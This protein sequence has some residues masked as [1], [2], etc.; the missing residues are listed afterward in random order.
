MNADHEVR[1]CGKTVPLGGGAG[2]RIGQRKVVLQPEAPE[3]VPRGR[4]HGGG[5]VDGEVHPVVSR[6][7]SA[8]QQHVAALSPQAP[9]QAAETPLGS[10]GD[11]HG[12][13]PPQ[14][15]S[16]DFRKGR[17]GSR[18]DVAP[19]EKPRVGRRCG[20]SRR[21]NRVV[22]RSPF[23]IE[24]LAEA[25]RNGVEV[26]ERQGPGRTIG[27]R[28]RRENDADLVCFFLD[29]ANPDG[30]RDVDSQDGR[31]GFA[32]GGAQGGPDVRL[33]KGAAKKARLCGLAGGELVGGRH[34]SGRRRKK[35]RIRSQ[36]ASGRGRGGLA[37]TAGCCT[38][39]APG[40]LRRQKERGGQSSSDE[41][42]IVV[43]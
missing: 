10:G 21:G 16:K 37:G 3:P 12:R 26:V 25:A 4:V 28:R 9:A 1:L 38:E 5:E 35:G 2:R 22:R 42:E 30:G 40:L 7:H 29:N 13:R 8:L 24:G 6:V 31:D 36:T 41:I 39:E 27:G 18:R 14:H 15:R 19:S 20:R 17:H 23:S 34:S 11:E 33:T 32:R 43:A